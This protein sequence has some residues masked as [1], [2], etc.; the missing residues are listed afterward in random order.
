L[1]N[2]ISSSNNYNIELSTTTTNLVTNT[3]VETINPNM[4][5]INVTN[6]TF[7]LGNLLYTA[8]QPLIL[9]TTLLISDFTL[10]CPFGNSYYYNSLEAGVNWPPNNILTTPDYCPNS[11]WANCSGQIVIVLT[12]VQNTINGSSSIPAA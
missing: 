11:G 5:D 10:Y 7:N 2:V 12:F 3:M 4:S 9:D 8:N 6:I 1:V